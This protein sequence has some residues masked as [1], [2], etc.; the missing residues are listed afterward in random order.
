MSEHVNPVNP[1]SV[2]A[3]LAEEWSINPL[4]PLPSFLEMVMIEEASRSMSNAIRTGLD[5]M[6]EKINRLQGLS[7]DHIDYLDSDEDTDDSFRSVARRTIKL[8]WIAFHIERSRL[9]RWL[10]TNLRTY[11]LEIQYGM[12][13]LLER[14]CLNSSSCARIAEAVYG[15]RRV[16]L[17]RNAEPGQTSGA[18]LSELSKDDRTRVAILA[19]FAPYIR[20]RMDQLY[21]KWERGQLNSKG[22]TFHFL[23]G[24]YPYLRFS[25]AGANLYSRWRF[26]LGKSFSYDFSMQILGQTVRRVTQADTSTSKES[27]TTSPSPID[28]ASNNSLVKRS[29]L[30]LVSV[31]VLVSWLTQVRI[32]WLNAKN[33]QLQTPPSPP[34][35]ADRVLPPETQ[36][37]CPI[38][39]RHWVNPAVCSTSGYVYCLTCILPFIRQYKKCPI[40]GRACEEVNLVRLFEP[41]QQVQHPNHDETR[42]QV[43]V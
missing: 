15:A 21:Q 36:D 17:I 27:N 14:H 39:K 40:S 12:L 42:D 32:R 35:P 8:Y 22:R 4:S 37:R 13:Y 23:M 28:M 33:Q 16:K 19:T 10:S 1:T 34:P 41:R 6:E 25:L 11:K 20:D 7:S 43:S 2:G 3:L 38:C 29:L 26:L 30:S 31:S 9:A 18:K 5:M 24:M